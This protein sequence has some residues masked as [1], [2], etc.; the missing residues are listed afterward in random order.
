MCKD[1]TRT[2]FRPSARSSSPIRGEETHEMKTALALAAL[3]LLVAA[4][5]VVIHDDITHHDYSNSLG[6]LLG[7]LVGLAY[8]FWWRKRSRPSI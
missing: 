5:V 1:L 4:A 7:A 2:L 3:V 6:G 8:L